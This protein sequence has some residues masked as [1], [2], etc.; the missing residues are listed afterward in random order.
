MMYTK[1][2][3]KY[4]IDVNVFNI[5]FCIVIGAFIGFFWSIITFSS[6]GVLFGLIGFKTFKNSEY[7]TYYNLGLTKAYLLKRVLVLNLF[8]SLFLILIYLIFV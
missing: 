3:W 8:I 6:F 5:A 2:I 4:F 7:Y 1:A